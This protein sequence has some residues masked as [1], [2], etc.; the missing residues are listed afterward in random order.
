MS[1]SEFEIKEGI[2]AKIKL[3]ESEYFENFVY[4]VADQTFTIDNK[5]QTEKL[6]DELLTQF[7]NKYSSADALHNY[8]L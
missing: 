4:T 2:E 7:K 3:I 6:I 5:K 8:I 1:K